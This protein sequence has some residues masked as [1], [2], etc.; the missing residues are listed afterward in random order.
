M[1]KKGK[2][3]KK[4]ERKVRKEVKSDKWLK[5]SIVLI[6]EWCMVRYTFPKIT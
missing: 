4:K 2:R 6:R 1:R 5:S 3:I